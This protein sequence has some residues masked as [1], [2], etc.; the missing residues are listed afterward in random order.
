MTK[1]PMRGIAILLGIMILTHVLE[2]AA[3]AVSRQVLHTPFVCVTYCCT[4]AV[5]KQHWYGY[6]PSSVNL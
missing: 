5:K 1:R 2:V 3:P 6:S 4:Y